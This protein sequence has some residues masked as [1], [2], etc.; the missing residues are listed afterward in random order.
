MTPINYVNLH[1][2]HNK[3]KHVLREVVYKANDQGTYFDRKKLAQFKITE[4]VK[5]DSIEIIVSLGIGNNE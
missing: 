1:F 5:V 2:T 4:P 3:T